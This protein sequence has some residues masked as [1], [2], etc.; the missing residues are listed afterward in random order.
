[1]VFPAKPYHTSGEPARLHNRQGGDARHRCRM[2]MLQKKGSMKMARFVLGIGLLVVL[3]SPFA[4]V[5]CGSAAQQSQA[6]LD[7]D[8]KRLI[9]E[10]RKGAFRQG[11]ERRAQIAKGK[12]VKSGPTNDAGRSGR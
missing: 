7:E 11:N 3:G 2:Q 12:F 10:Q 9:V 5:G 8:A 1:M 6:P 4:V